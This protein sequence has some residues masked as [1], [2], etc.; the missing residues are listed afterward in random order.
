M[1]RA[2]LFDLGNTLVDEETNRPL[3]G[4]TGLLE[5]LADVHDSEGRPVLSGVVSDWKMPRDPA[6][7]GPLR[8]E[9]L[10]QL[11]TSG[12][13]AFFRPVETRV[14]LSTDI[15]VRKPDAAIFRAALDNLQPGLPFHQAIFVTERLQHVQAARILGLLAIHFRGP[16]QTTGDVE[17]FADLLDLLQRIILATPPRK[18][19][20]EAVGR[21]DSQAAKSKQA[22]DDLA[23]IVAQVSPARL[24]N[25]IR[26]LSGFGTRWTYSSNIG[27][28]P[29]WVRDRFLEMGYPESDVRFQ[30]FS[31]PGAGQQQNVLCGA[32][33]DHPGFVLVCAHYDSL[34]ETP[35]TTAPGSDDNAS[36]LVVL[37]EVA[38]L[39]R[40]SPVR[41]GLLFAAFGG[42][43]QGLL[44][45]TACAEVAAA[46]QWRIDVVIN[47]DMVAFQSP[48]R[49]NL[50][51]VEYDQGN[52]HPG[53]DPAAKAFGLMM[54]QAAADYT[55][56]AIEHTDIWNSDYMPFEAKGYAAIGVYE[57]GE[58]P[59]YHKSTD[60]AETVD[61]N[62]LAEVSKMVL[63]T[64]YSIAR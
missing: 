16:G 63:A 43:E 31:V 13:D 45:S 18:K 22:D 15:G 32:P 59:H 61:L 3:P 33:A 4:A 60:T 25:R 42:E 37:L 17:R 11:A 50:V 29:A 54:A 24:G 12:L 6:E 10:R 64:V 58:N 44:G 27:R 21:S 62:H 57:G 35:S 51:R 48:V 53:N 1:T 39:L 7:A 55:N 5:A 49:P 14:T 30:P 34:S 20:S 36:G 46:E 8:Q 56:L 38:E 52:H 40:T 9:Y 41:R 28:V 26:E 2:V 19:H 23:A 47:L